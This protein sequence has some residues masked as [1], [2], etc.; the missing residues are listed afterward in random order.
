MSQATPVDLRELSI[1]RG[2]AGQPKLHRRK[3]FITRYLLPA[4]LVFGFLALVVWAARDSIFPPKSVTVMTVISSTSEVQQAGTPLFQAAGWI[5]PRPTPVRVAALA[6]GVVEELLVVEDQLMQKGEPIAQLVK[7]DAVL[8]HESALVD[9]DL[10]QAEVQ[11]AEA[12]LAAAVTRFEKPV[13]LQAAVGEA[14]AALAKIETVLRNL[15]F[16]L[17]RAEAEYIASLKD[18][19]GKVA[20]RE[21]IAGIEIDKAE[22]E[23]DS[24]KALVEELKDRMSSLEKEQL[25][26]SQ[27]RNALQIQLELLADELKEMNEAKARLT[28]AQARVAQ[29]EVSVAEEKLRLD[30]MT[31]RSPVD[32]R[33]FRLIAH[34]GAR[35]GSG[36]TQMAG[37]DGSTVVTM[38]IPSKLQVRVDVR[39]EDIPKVILGQQV[40]IGNPA[41][42]A[43]ILGRVLFVSSEADIQKNTLQVKVEITEPPAFFKPEMLVDVTFLAPP[44]LENSE[45]PATE[46]RLYVPPELIHQGEGGSYVWIADRSENVA[47][48]QSVQTRTQRIQGLVEITSGVNLATRIIVHGSDQLEDGDRISVTG[49]AAASSYSEAPTSKVEGN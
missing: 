15:P 23:K 10:R 1:D 37:H 18:Y 39:F 19:E 46:L 27:K 36:M 41:L 35:I 4:I 45:E 49:E 9:Q 3:H 42:T 14:E 13:H 26:L 7:D 22:S 11:A 44:R 34:P 33:I 31:I 5:E 47:R 20:A 48:K 16:E 25:A 2:D 28:A 17:R 38:Y 6:P 8:S 24:R 21:V 29:A 32:G 12:T 30:R 43:P 40:E